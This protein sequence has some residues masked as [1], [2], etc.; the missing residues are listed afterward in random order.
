MSKIKFGTDGWRAILNKDFT[1]ENTDNLVEI[2][3][4]NINIVNKEVK[5]SY[6]KILAKADM[7]V[8]IVYLTEDNRINEVKWEI[9]VMGF[10]D[11]QNISEDSLIDINYEFQIQNQ[12]TY[13][14]SLFHL[15]QLLLVPYNH[16]N[17]LLNLFYPSL[18]V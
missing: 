14:C 7:C 9:P 17:L 3:K 4:T 6:N 5:T 16:I 12:H 1:F 15:L 13:T 10:I 18:N 8:S 11:M 2:M